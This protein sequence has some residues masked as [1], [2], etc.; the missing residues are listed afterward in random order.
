MTTPDTAPFL[1]NKNYTKMKRLSVLILSAAL[2]TGSANAQEWT[3]TGSWPF[4][5]KAF[6]PAT[7]VTGFFKLKKTVVPCNIHVGKQTLWYSQN[8]T[9]MEAVPGTVLRV[10]FKDASYIPVNNSDF[11]KVLREDSIKGKPA[12]VLKVWTV[13]Q[14]ELD[15]RGRDAINMTSNILQ[16]SGA[17]ASLSTRIADAN[18]GISEEERPLPMTNK[19]YFIFNGEIFEATTSNILKHIDPKRKA[20][21]RNFTRSAEIISTNESS[22]LKIWDKFF[23]HWE[24][25][26]KK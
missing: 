17:L 24:K 16:S 7:V 3:P 9:L 14:R 8:D 26:S 19:F 11:G 25:E 2:L 23:L 12:K 4:I 18:G 1:P 10:D 6:R 21:Y 22:I 5:N 13:D 15:A 20:E